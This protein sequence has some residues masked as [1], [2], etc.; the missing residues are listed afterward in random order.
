MA[1]SLAKEEKPKTL[2]TRSFSC[3]YQTE[4]I[5]SCEI[6]ILRLVKI[7]TQLQDII[8]FARVE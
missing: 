3:T 4:F 1:V 5:G 6:D 7:L 8:G 2:R